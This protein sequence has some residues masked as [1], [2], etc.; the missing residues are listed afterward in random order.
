[1]ATR[2]SVMRLTV[3][4]VFSCVTIVA[5]GTRLVLRP[6]GPLTWADNSAI[7]VLVVVLTLYALPTLVAAWRHP[8]DL[9]SVVALNVLLG[10]TLAGWAISLA[11]ALRDAPPAGDPAS[12]LKTRGP[13]ESA[14]ARCGRSVDPWSPRTCPGCGAVL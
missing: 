11:L 13:Q 5:I 4:G 14:C 6:T 3:G 2:I 10:W 8:P 1:M 12:P 7:G 9:G